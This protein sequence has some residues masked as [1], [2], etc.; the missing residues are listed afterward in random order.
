[1][2]Y[3]SYEPKA[4]VQSQATGDEIVCQVLPA[5]GMCATGTL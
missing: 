1:M 5:I 2:L 4:V 3:G